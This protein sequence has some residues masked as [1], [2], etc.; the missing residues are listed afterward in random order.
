MEPC[1]HGR[2]G[3]FKASDD[4][5]ANRHCYKH[6]RIYSNADTLATGSGP[7][8]DIDNMIKF[9]STSTCDQTGKCENITTCADTRQ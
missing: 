6:S 5:R 1:R 3:S 9:A 8:P 7:G 2:E 4:D